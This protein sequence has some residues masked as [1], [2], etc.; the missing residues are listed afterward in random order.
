VGTA[1]R[2]VSR[3][4]AFAD[5]PEDD[6][7]TR[8]RKRVGIIAGYLTMF[9]PLFLP[10]QAGFSAPSVALAIAQSAYST[11]NLLLLL[12]TGAFERYVVALVGSGVVFVPAATVIGGGLT[13]ETSGL[14]WGFLIPA[15]AIM[16]LGPARAT[17][18]FLA[19]LAGSV[20]LVLIDPWAR[21]AFGPAA[22]EAVRFT[23]EFNS[24]VPLTIVFLLLRW[25]DLRRRAAEARSDALLTN[26]IPRAIADRLR[27]GEER[28]AELYPET[29]VLFADIVDF[30]PWA[31]RTD[32]ATVVS[33]LDDLFSRFDD[34]AAAE[35]VE[36]IK[37]V[38][39]AYMAVAGAPEKRQDHAQAAIGLAQEMLVAADKWRTEHRVSLAI[40]IGIASGPVVAGVIG[41]RRL[42]FDLWGDT[43]NTASRLEAAGV[44]GRIQV[45]EGTQKRL[46]GSG[47]AFEPRELDIKGL[48]HVRAYLVG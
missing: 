23:T 40:R 42:L 31:S 14:N 16:A 1:R 21:Q 45:S 10:L 9:A 7:D 34:L 6:D 46:Q 29:T 12:R 2:W 26:A 18:W 11:A 30:T 43:V 37:T 28:I 8:L 22:Y 15:Y 5:R 44:P 20:G 19:F 33:L 13:G 35:G 25:T 27:H 3:S 32:P 4:I 17:P 41:R 24:V 48:G 38:G 47:N 36:K 39:D